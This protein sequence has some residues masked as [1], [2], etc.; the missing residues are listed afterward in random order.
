[1]LVPEADPVEVVDAVVPVEGVEAVVW[2][3]CTGELAWVA[4]RPA[5]GSRLWGDCAVAT[6]AAKLAG[7]AEP[8]VVVAVLALAADEAV[9]ADFPPRI[10]S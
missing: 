7:T 8:A 6:W 10:E 2:D 9:E 3:T 5:A 1:L 4:A